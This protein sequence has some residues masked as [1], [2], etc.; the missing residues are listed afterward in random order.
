VP[1]PSSES[2]SIFDGPRMPQIDP[3]SFIDDY[4]QRGR[5]VALGTGIVM[6]LTGADCP[7]AHERLCVAALRAGVDTSQ[8]AAF[9]IGLYDD[10][11]G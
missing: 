11:A 2:A 5:R 9:L 7:A 1:G 6:H 10:S 8:A 3:L 4:V